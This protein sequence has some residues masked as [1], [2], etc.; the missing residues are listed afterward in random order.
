MTI[1]RDSIIWWVSMI[2]GVAVGVSGSF[3]LFPWITPG[4]QHGISLVGFIYGVVS[5]K[6]ATSPLPISPEGHAK[7]VEE[8]QAALVDSIKGIVTLADH[9][10]LPL[11]ANP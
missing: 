3:T 7:E 10:P 8:H 11:L 2:G 6:M 5:G 4:W 1:T 9:A